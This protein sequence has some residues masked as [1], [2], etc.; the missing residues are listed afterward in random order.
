VPST[1]EALAVVVIALIPGALYTWAFERL[2]GRWGIGFSDRLFRFIGVSALLHALAAPVTYTLWRDFLREQAQP[3]LN[4][5]PLWMWVVALLYV[6]VPSALGYL[7]ALG[8]QRQWKP[9]R[10]VLGSSSAPTAWDAIFS[11]N[12]AG[13]ILMRLKSG[14]WVGGEYAEGSYAGGYPEPADLF[15]S[16]ECPIDQESGNFIL[17]RVGQ[18]LANGYGILV[19]WDDVEYLEVTPTEAS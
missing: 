15:L 10:A 14:A 13:W 3:G 19:R 17:D 4:D 11:G 12:P 8:Y 5:L 7:V 2:V 6:A 9:I 18:P 1:V 16:K